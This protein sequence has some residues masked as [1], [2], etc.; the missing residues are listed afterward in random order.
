MSLSN[1]PTNIHITPRSPSFD[2]SDVPKV[3]MKD[4]ITTHFMNALSI[5]IPFSER[6]VS[7]ILRA[8][9]EDIPDTLLKSQ[10]KD[11]IK[12]EGRHAAM[13]RK[14]NELIRQCYSG[15]NLVEKMQSFTIKLIRKLSSKAFELSIPAAFEHFTSAVSREILS[16]QK[17]WTGSKDNASINFVLW[18]CLEE[19][20][21]QAICHDAYKALYKSRL[22]LFL[23]LA[24]WIPLSMIS[25]YGIQLYLMH[26]D[27][28]IYKP[29]K[30][31]P[32]VKFLIRSSSLFYRGAFQFCRKGFTPWSETDQALYQQAIVQFQIRQ[33]ANN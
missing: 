31:L 30:W 26:K 17:Q 4:D 2:F 21:H 12:Q 23:S 11:M 28:V 6:S 16:N 24:L 7:E 8:N 32:Y 14:S 27:R 29:K 1:T 33:S 25:I 15:L 9:L 19:L 20:E 22:R 5:F 13:H 10:V 18:H 3:W